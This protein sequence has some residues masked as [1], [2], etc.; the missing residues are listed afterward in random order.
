MMK[1]EKYSTGVEGRFTH[2]GKAQLSAIMKAN[3]EGGLDMPM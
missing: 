2:Q 3:E 1:L